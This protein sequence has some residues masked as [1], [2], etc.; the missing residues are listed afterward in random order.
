MEFLAHMPEQETKTREP[1]DLKPSLREGG[2]SGG[3][4][5]QSGGMS[6]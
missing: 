3:E 6:S 2:H 4:Q 1:V 5:T